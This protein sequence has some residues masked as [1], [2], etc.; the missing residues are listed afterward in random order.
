ML[1]DGARPDI[2]QELLVSSALPNIERE[3]V[4]QGTFRVATSCAPSTTGP[5]YLPFLTG[6]FPGTVNIPGIRWLDKTQFRD[7]RLGLSRMRSYNGI[8]GP[9]LNRDLPPSCKTLFEIFDHPFNIFSMITRGLPKGNNLT[10]FSKPFAYTYA[11]ITDQWGFVDR[12]AARRLVKALDQDPDFI[13][14][15]FP[16]V[17]SFSHLFNPRHDKTIAAYRFVDSTVGKIVEKLK[18]LK[19]WEETLLIITSDHGLTATHRHLDLALFLQHRKL[20]TLYYPIIWKSRPRFSVMVSG[21]AMAQVYCL[22]VPGREVCNEHLLRK[23][24]GASWDELFEQAAVDFVIWRENRAQYTI[25]NSQGRACITTQD[26][27]LTYDPVT[28]DPLAY[29]SITK[30][31]TRREALAATFDSRYPDALV[32]IE[33]LFSSPRCGDFVVISKNNYDLRQAYEWPEHHA[34]HGSLHR[35][36]MIVPLIYNQTGWKL[37]PARTADI[38]NTILMWTGKSELP[39]TDGQSLI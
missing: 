7:K 33:Q 11:H 12:L 35:E 17:D 15:V 20:D 16:N 4:R 5:A 6:Y 1:I 19:R 22:D 2:M 38:F 8:E 29:G 18:K 32:Q 28:A 3:I 34:S 14:A 31:L 24:L 10:R 23:S 36:H 13:F 39:D 21:N 26:T 25:Q 27:G 9:L 37:R 30:P